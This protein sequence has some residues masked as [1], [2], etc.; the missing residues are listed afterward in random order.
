[1][2]LSCK[3]PDRLSRWLRW[4]LFA[5]DN[6]TTLGTVTPTYIRVRAVP[7]AI[8]P[9]YITKYWDV[10]ASAN[11]NNTTATFQYDPAELNGAAAAITYSP[12]FGTT[13]QNPPS[14]GTSSYGSNSFTITGNNP[15]VGRWTMGYRSYYSYQTGDWNNPSTWTSDPS[16]T[17]QVG[18]TIPGLND[19]VIIL[20]GRTVSL[21]GDI[22]ST[23]LDIT[24]EQGGFLDLTTRRFTN[25][26]IALRGE[27][28]LRLASVNF[29]TVTTNTFINAG[30]GTTEYYNSANFTLPS[31]PA[32]Y[33][34]LIINSSGFTAT[35]LS[36]LTL[37]GNLNVKSGTFRI[38]D[39]ISTTKLTL[40]INGN[41]TV[42]NGAF[43]TVGN[44]VTNTA[45]GGSGGAA[46]FL[47]YYLNFHT[48]IIKGDFT[49]NGTV[50]FTNLLFPVFN[51][52]PPTI[53]GATSGAASVYFQGPSDNNIT[54]N[55]ITDFY[56][57]IVDKGI[58]QT[59]KLT[60]NS[61]NYIK[62]Q[63]FRSQYFRQL[64]ELYQNNPGI[65]KALWIRN[66]TLILKGMLII[67]S[68]SEGTVATA[69]YYIPANGALLLD[70]VD[71][72]LLSSADD[73][74]EIN[75]AY[76]VAA[77][78]N[79]TIGVGTGGFSALNVFGK[80]Q[81]NNGFLSTRESGGIVTSSVASGQIII[82]GGTV[83]TKQFLS[84]TG[85]ASYTQTGGVFILRGRFQRTPVAY[86][87]I[88]N[89][90]DVSMASLNTSRVVNGIN[91][92][93]G[94]FNLENPSNIYTVSG[95]TIRIYDVSESGGSEKAIDI[96][97]SSSNI[98]VTGGNY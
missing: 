95:G 53:S 17:L 51:A 76:T 35:Q 43:I 55:G 94:T 29:P 37:N 62:F 13:W 79:G 46:P 47:N 80:L 64:M 59:Y 16:G 65:R 82:N 40:T 81:I 86:S 77:P 56:N 31:A 34:N 41:V 92:A 49:N 30:G 72:A 83:D 87:T 11:L 22:T 4:L 21:S 50:R 58:D 61:T 98:N 1:M 39:N 33:N 71:V 9:S 28:T 27:G 20:S 70:G 23:G 44:G 93:F 97:A 10:N 8:N 84:S 25:T 24:I 7:T 67:P 91:P 5:N 45:I 75:T 38:N 66:G 3:L 6:L 14:S 88:A 48:V 2:G 96:K 57:L 90:T 73:Y 60:I 12:D 18:T 68:L 54:C 78:D 19:K 69:D 63:T 74:R 42:D 85:S 36:N 15:F 52:F 32:I 89:L 26:L